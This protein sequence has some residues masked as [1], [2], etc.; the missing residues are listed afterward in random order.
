[1]ILPISCS[2][3]YRVWS[4]GVKV[5]QG[6][7]PF[8]WIRQKR[9]SCLL[10]KNDLGWFE[11]VL[12]V[13]CG[14]LMVKTVVVTVTEGLL[15]ALSAAAPPVDLSR[16]T[17]KSEGAL[18]GDSSTS[19]RGQVLCKRKVGQTH[20]KPHTHLCWIRRKSNIFKGLLAN[21]SIDWSP[22]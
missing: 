20:P 2:D 16:L 8:D 15:L 4:S 13:S 10:F 19:W 9:R 11:H 12:L 3:N 5:T 14:P 7:I 1:M 18:I 6:V 17:N 22:T 21:Q